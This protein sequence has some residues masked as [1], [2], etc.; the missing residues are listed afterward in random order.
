MPLLAF[1]LAGYHAQAAA[2]SAVAH[3]MDYC[4]D[5]LTRL[6]I[7]EWPI[8][9]PNK[10]V[11]GP[12]L[13]SFTLL[14]H[15]DSSNLLEDSDLCNPNH[16]ADHLQACKQLAHLTHLDVSRY[17]VFA[18]N[19]VAWEQGC[20]LAGLSQLRSLKLEEDY[21]PRFETD[22]VIAIRDGL[23]FVECAVSA[24]SRARHATFLCAAATGC[25]GS[26]ISALTSLQL[27]GTALPDRAG[28]AM[29]RAL[30]ALPM[31]EHLDLAKHCLDEAGL[32]QLASALPSLPRL[33]VLMLSQTITQSAVRPGGEHERDVVSVLQRSAQEGMQSLARHDAD[34]ARLVR[35]P[36]TQPAPPVLPPAADS[37]MCLEGVCALVDGI[38]GATALEKL[39]LQAVGMTERAF[40]CLLDTCTTLARLSE[41][42]LANNVL[43]GGKL[44][45]VFARSI[46]AYSSL[47]LIK[48]RDCVPL[49]L[50]L[51]DVQG[52]Q[53]AWHKA[54]GCNV[55]Y[56]D[57]AL[58][59]TLP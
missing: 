3:S 6:D 8:V 38:A 7:G 10:E 53:Q 42:D 4:A 43:G 59:R 46:A 26:G 56:Q 41:L 1:P 58:T 24:A 57:Q 20:W 35:G 28:A 17:G 51:V 23:R 30:P 37:R 14:R 33:R 27:A 2:V 21:F 29:A 52:M 44:V 25:A 34:L 22:V 16:R 55:E 32:A 36:P 48:L 54:T 31:L 45:P 50:A 47:Q 13:S 12:Q 40:E 18:S 11:M 15:L 19:E 39:E 5:T 49:G 9:P